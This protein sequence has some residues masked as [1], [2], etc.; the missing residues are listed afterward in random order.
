VD[1]RVDIADMRIYEDDSVDFFICSHV[2]EHVPHDRQAL[3][4]LCRVLK[5]AGRG[6]IM[7]PL[8][9][10]VDETQEDPSVDTDALRWKYY[11]SGDHIRQYGKRDFLGRLADAGF[12]VDQLGIDYF[13][14][15]AFRRAGIAADSVLYVV[16]KAEG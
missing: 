7:V 12:Q 9:H 2:L 16:R 1:D 3:R 4:E 8:V 6:I 13:G 15:E 14:N 10:G 5:P 11:G